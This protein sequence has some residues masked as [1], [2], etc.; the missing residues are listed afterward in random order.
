MAEIGLIYFSGCLLAML[1]AA[2]GNTSPNLFIIALL[3]LFTLPY[4]LFSIIYQGFI[5]RSWCL[6]CLSVMAI[7]WIEFYILSGIIF[8]GNSNYST[9]GIATFIFGYIVSIV[10]WAGLRSRLSSYILRLENQN[11]RMQWMIYKLKAS[12]KK[13]LK[14]TGDEG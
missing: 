4:T 2:I 6:L 14:Q 12:K 8:N 9:T 7:F 3:N 11:Q 10:I 13:D 1:P 5:I